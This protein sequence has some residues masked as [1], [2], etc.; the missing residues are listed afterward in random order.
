MNHALEDPERERQRDKQTEA[1]RERQREMWH[2]NRVSREDVP[3][4]E[5]KM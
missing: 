4:E 2:R 1:Y 5:H 3:H